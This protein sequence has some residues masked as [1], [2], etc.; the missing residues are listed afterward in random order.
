[1]GRDRRSATNPSLAIPA[2]AVMA[3]TIRASI[4]AR[5]MARLGSPPDPARGRITAA[6]IGP[7]DESGP[8]TRI[9]DGPRSAYPSRH[10]IEVYRPV[11]AGRPASSAYAI[12]WGTRSAVSTSPA[13]RS[14]GSHSL[15]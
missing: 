1:V 15:R 10:M 14:F 7:R 2:I 3:P 9:F 5:A 6:I 4:E 11:I 13:T 12:P 8:S